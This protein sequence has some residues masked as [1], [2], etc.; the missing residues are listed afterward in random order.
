M[1]VQT[2]RALKLYNMKKNVVNMMQTLLDEK[3]IDGNGHNIYE[4]NYYLNYI[5]QLY[6]TGLENLQRHHDSI[7]GIGISSY[8]FHRWMADIIKEVDHE[9]TYERK[10]GRGFEATEIKKSVQLWVL[11]N[12]EIL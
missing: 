10:M 6:N 9:F 4:L 1:P 3:I 5:P 8:E 7:Q 2:R 12:K 11:E